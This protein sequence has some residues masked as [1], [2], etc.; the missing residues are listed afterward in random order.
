MHACRNPPYPKIGCCYIGREGLVKREAAVS[1]LRKLSS[2]G[3]PLPRPLVL[4]V[5]CRT[6][7]PI[8]KGR[9]R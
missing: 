3:L 2:G 8:D 9:L 1:S 4:L 7:C 6:L 5:L